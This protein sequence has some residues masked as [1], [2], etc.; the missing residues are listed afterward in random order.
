MMS[1]AQVFL[2]NDKIPIPL[3]G[4]MALLVAFFVVHGT[5]VGTNLEINAL[6]GTLEATVGSYLLKLAGGSNTGTRYLPIRSF[7]PNLQTCMDPRLVEFHNT[8]KQ[9]FTF[10]I[11]DHTA[12]RVR[13]AGSSKLKPFA[14]ISSV[15]GTAAIASSSTW[16]MGALLI[17]GTLLFTG[18]SIVG[19]LMLFQCSKRRRVQYHKSLG[20]IIDVEF[21]TDIDSLVVEDFCQFNRKK[22][23]KSFKNIKKTIVIFF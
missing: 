20:T 12:R 1:A 19:S 11:E 15:T 17:G 6:A 10:V 22:I 23:C 8:C 7:S 9:M 4:K 5:L 3:E 18:V 14:L 21:K 16:T 2:Q 13:F